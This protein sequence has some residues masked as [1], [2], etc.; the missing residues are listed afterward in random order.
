MAL[1]AGVLAVPRLLSER[2]DPPPAP[3]GSVAV[4]ALPVEIIRLEPRPLAE[5]LATTGSVRANE[6]VNLVS[7]IS[8]VV[9]SISFREGASVARGDLLV[10]LDDAELLAQSSRVEYRLRL[11][12]T[13]EKRQREL[14]EQ[15][16]V[17]EQDYDVA[18]NELSVLRAEQRL[19]D[20]QLDK[21]E[22]RAPFSG[23]VGLRRISE[24]SLLSPQTLITTLQ[25]LDPIKMDF[26][27]PEKY[28]GRIKPGSR[29]QFRVKGSGRRFEAEVYAVEP[30]IDPET[31]SLT[32]RAGTPNS[33]GSLVPGAFADVLLEVGLVERALV[34]PSLAV[35]PELGGMKVF[36]LE[37][38][39]ARPRTVETGMRTENEVQITS[40]L[41]AGEVVI[42]SAIQR[43]RPGLSVVP[44]AAGAGADSGSP[45]R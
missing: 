17:S 36:V 7:E 4:A 40:G 1:V 42:V 30:L 35:I 44:L 8:G 11:A 20:V 22:I 21:T 23:V 32:V 41:E 45:S 2:S 18:S 43:L 31:R 34:V 26:T 5:M 19:V 24:G 33:D 15:G 12:E 38:G 25:D 29:V 28:S 39:L 6:Q 27:I 9:R 3:A 13:R 14:S 16:V 10:K 37:N